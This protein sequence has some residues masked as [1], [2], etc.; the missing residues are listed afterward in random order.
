MNKQ[1]FTNNGHAKFPVTT[2][3][4]DFLQQQI[5]LTARLASLAGQNV[6][7][8]DSTATTD[9][10]VIYDGELLPLRGTP[11]SNIT[12]A[13]TT[14]SITAG[15]ETFTDVRIIRTA[16]YVSSGG[17]PT[18]SFTVIDNIATLM[19]RL[20]A[21][22]TSIGNVDTA[23]RQLI[24]TETNNRTSADSGLSTRISTIESNYMT[25]TAIAAEFAKYMLT[26]DIN[27]K[28]AQY[29]L[30]TDINKALADNAQ[31]HLPKGSIIDWYGTAE[32]DNIPYGFVPCGIIGNDFSSVTKTASEISKWKQRYEQIT[33]NQTPYSTSRTFIITNC[34]GQFV[35]DLTDRFTVQAGN[36]YRLQATGGDKE[37]S[38]TAAQVGISSVDGDSWRSGGSDSDS[39]KLTIYRGVASSNSLASFNTTAHNNLPPYYALYK[40]I[41]VI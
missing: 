22:N 11:K 17:R 29:M 20:I 32:C 41:K 36:T 10:L 26:T 6:I 24:T 39:K 30:T 3:T 40:L 37:V 38:L 31:H 9:G 23:L 34:L 13:E 12:V 5:F 19:T 27:A 14:Q 1:L 28:F 8:K 35:P 16:E 33:I 25:K 7:I 21:L 4:L 2:E 15:T 18:Q